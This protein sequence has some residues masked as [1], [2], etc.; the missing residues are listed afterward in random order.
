MLTIETERAVLIDGRL[1]QQTIIASQ[2]FRVNIV[3]S[4]V[5]HLPTLY[6]MVPIENQLKLVPDKML[7]EAD[8]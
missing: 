2:Y 6:R 4:N 5:S 1:E 3:S 7:A 8:E